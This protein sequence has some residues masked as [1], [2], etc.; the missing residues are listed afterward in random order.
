MTKYDSLIG[1]IKLISVIEDFPVG[2]I[3]LDENGR[4]MLANKLFLDL[5]S[6]TKEKLVGKSIGSI[7]SFP[8]KDIYANFQAFFSTNPLANKQ[9]AEIKKKNGIV[10]RIEFSVYRSESDHKKFYAGYVIGNEEGKDL[11]NELEKQINLKDSIKDQL[12]QQN[13]LSEMKSRFLSLA[14]HEFRT[15]LASIMSS[16]NLISRYLEAD[17]QTWY[18]FRNRQKVANHLDKIHESV[19]NLTTILSKFLALESIEKGEI[20]VRLVK[21]NMEIALK[22]IKSQ[23]QELCKPGQKIFYQHNGKNASVYLDKYLLK[24]IMNNLLS[25]AIK[26][27]HEDAEIRLYSKV[28]ADKISIELQDAGIGI[29]KAD[30]NKI[31]GRFF[32]ASNAQTLQ[33]G[34]GLGLNIV[35]KYVEIMHGQIHFESEEN[36]GTTFYITFPNKSI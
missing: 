24:N 21:F 10:Y 27:S 8:T 14:S 6:F 16:L 7:L 1:D 13:E 12:E 30:Q 17:Q 20:P 25:N 34:T 26:F 4:I 11:I 23:F 33:D 22:L 18:K 3:L 9:T 35:K 28:T 2:I 32:R 36:V 31:F 19:N 15:P 5:F 29:P